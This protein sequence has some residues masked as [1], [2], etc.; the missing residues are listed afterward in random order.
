[1]S[2]LADLLAHATRDRLRAVR[3]SPASSELAFVLRR[4]LFTDHH[5]DV[6][7]AAALR[8]GDLRR[9]QPASWLVDA[10]V[11]HAPV[12]RDAI[13]RALAKLGDPSATPAVRD[14]AA[15]DRVW[16]VRRA[17]VYALG[18]LGGADELAALEAVLDDPFW[19]VRLAAVKVLAALGA[20]DLEV[21]AAIAE[22]ASPARAYLRGSWGPVAVEQPSPAATGASALPAELLD[23]D[24]AVVTARLAAMPHVAPLALVELLCD[25]H[26]P[27]R[28]LAAERI[29]ASGDAAAY[30]AALDWLEEPRVPHVAELVE[31]LLDHVGDAAA[32]VAAF[33]LA[34]SDRDGA[35]R[36]AVRW[37]AATSFDPLADAA[38]ARAR[39]ARSL[40]AMA[41]RLAETDELVSW[42]ADGD[43][44]AIALELYERH[45]FTALLALADPPHAARA[46]Q[47]DAAA[48]SGAWDHVHAGLADPHH[49]P[50][51]VATSALV[52]ERMID[53]AAQLAD[54]DPAVREAALTPLSAPRAV[55]DRDPF[56]ARAAIA[57][58]AA[59]YGV[60]R[61]LPADVQTAVH[62]AL[63]SDDP[64]LRADALRV[65]LVADAALAR[66]IELLGDPDEAVRS[67][68]LA[69]LE[70]TDGVDARLGSL[71]ETRMIRAWLTG[72]A[73]AEP[74]IELAE[75]VRRAP[76]AIDQRA[77][78]R[79]GFGV[80]PLAISGAFELPETALA[81]AEDAGVNLWFWEPAYS[82]MTRFLRGSRG[83]VIAGSYHADVASIEHDVDRALRTL[84]RDA[85]D[86]LLLFWTRS[87][88]R[89]DAAAYETLQRL[90]GKVR[91]LGFSTHDRGLAASA[92]AESPWDV[93][94]IRHSAAHPGIE[95][96]LLPLARERGTA[97]V[98]F[99]ALCYGRMLGG[100]NP[101]AA[102]DCYRYSL[103]Q[104][105]VTACIS[106]PRRGRELVENL[107]V[108][109]R[110]VLDESAL[111]ALRSHGVGV[112][113]ESQRFNALMRQPTR[114]AA[115]AA[116]EMLAADLPPQ[117][118]L[119]PR[120]LPRASSK[121]VART[122]LHRARR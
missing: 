69:A 55:G 71:P 41:V 103:S 66:A 51:A 6:R 86:V 91:T 73:D 68:A 46:L 115:A 21:R 18:A 10:L 58:I 16:W 60:A 112:R 50:R 97:I 67:A 72:Q 8:L 79:A 121:R 119:D 2:G 106:A 48:R 62:A 111:A 96:E 19:R 44:D 29:A 99:S 100:P 39:E 95:T 109:A 30:R 78:G 108:L 74:V 28:L 70:R 23:P 42:S 25:P 92:I 118:E 47:I 15:T 11:D 120:P 36:W 104:P 54:R 4:V 110:P 27:L 81:R 83:H 22:H 80:A 65:P 122:R 14:V 53:G 117:D 76:P 3:R 20:R 56:V 89:V 114:D 113:A 85:L 26:A 12:V 35:A 88:A 7:A 45:A 94:M 31:Q 37:V 34:R 84:H 59:T 38:L 9:A 24:P 43:V 101:P 102:A 98:T 1:M 57:R 90:R 40:R 52:R 64:M 82:H 105:G 5:A 87:G 107:E 77:F 17:A 32:D 33:A 75:P 49:A 116:R 63:A 61:E 93:V 13:L